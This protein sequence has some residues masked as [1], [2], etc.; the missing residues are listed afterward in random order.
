MIA[1]EIN[2]E[3]LELKP[4]WK[5]SLD[6]DGL[7]GSP[8]D[9]AY[10]MMRGTMPLKSGQIATVIWIGVKHGGSDISR[11]DVAEACFKMGTAKAAG[12]ATSFVMSLVSGGQDVSAEVSEGEG[13]PIA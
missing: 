10:Q 3:S 5:A 12:I 4:T 11:D 8:V 9:D 7:I 1:I 2:G 13:K 6:Y